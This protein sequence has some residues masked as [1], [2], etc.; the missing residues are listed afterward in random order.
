MFI[1]TTAMRTARLAQA[2]SKMM[3]D[4][5]DAITFDENGEPLIFER[6]DAPKEIEQLRPVGKIDI[7][8]EL[9]LIRKYEE[10]KPCSS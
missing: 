4:S 5:A 6:H 2:L 1:E 8:R 7:S 3:L 10:K 9:E